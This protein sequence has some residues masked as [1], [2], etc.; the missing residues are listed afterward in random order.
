MMG[1]EAVPRFAWMWPALALGRLRRGLLAA[2]LADATR[3]RELPS[4]YGRLFLPLAAVALPLALS[5]LHALRASWDYGTV[6]ADPSPWTFLIWTTF[7]ESVSF[8]VLAAMLGIAAPA[9]GVI[10][11]S[12]YGVTDLAAAL[13]TNEM[14]A[15]PGAVV[16]RLS[17]YLLLWLL[18][19]EFPILA[20]TM[21]EIVAPED[22]AA[23]R[24]RFVAL[25]IASVVTG[26]LVFIWAEGARQLI[27]AVHQ[28]SNLT[29]PGGVYT[30][31]Y[32]TS[33]VVAV[34]CGAFTAVAFWF[35]YLGPRAYTSRDEAIGPGG[36]GR[37]LLS[38]VLG[39][40]VTMLLLVGYV[41]QPIDAVLLIAAV[42]LARPLAIAVLRVTRLAPV[43]VRIPWPL[44]LIAGFVVLF[45]LSTAYLEAVGI[46]LVSRFGYM[47][48]AIAV[49][50]VLIELLLAAEDAL[51]DGPSGTARAAVESAAIGTLI[52][53]AFPMV[54][55][56]HSG[57][58]EASAVAGA[59][60]AAAATA[61][62]AAKASRMR[63]PPNSRKRPLPPGTIFQVD[64]DMMLKGAGV[65][66]PK[67]PP[68]NAF[69]LSRDMIRK[70]LR[71]AK[72][73]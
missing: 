1:T 70:I 29:V 8:V 58:Q 25:A 41:D 31:L 55:A 18:V 64:P 72:P 43:L 46:S 45:L 6:Y 36:E 53:L 48:I 9:A 39:A 71:Q 68:L 17:S 27:A 56:A 52:L 32:Y 28:L 42:V 47:V 57:H 61:A 14:H 37:P 60:A 66:K 38:Y 22:D 30:Q 33:P 50:L 13:M 15:F 51:G 73:K 2:T 12:V 3:L 67:P 35:R 54:V 63:R 62:A 4:W 21:Y 65:P 10:V 34:V 44:R 20:R 26:G 19:V 69:Q 23:R 59:A 16:G 11:V 40:G 24:R 49:G 5:I 7:T